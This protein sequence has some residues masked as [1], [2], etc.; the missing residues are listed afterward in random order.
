MLDNGS[1]KGNIDISGVKPI[2]IG[3]DPIIA[4]IKIVDT[5][6]QRSIDDRRNRVDIDTRGDR[7]DI[8]RFIRDSH[9]N[10]PRRVLAMSRV[11]VIIKIIAD[12]HRYRR[13]RIVPNIISL[14]SERIVR[15]IVA[16]R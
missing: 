14:I 2:I 12:I 15:H 6:H 10:I 16:D 4:I 3:I 1:I 13:S 7:F 9:E 11:Q 5:E 8:T